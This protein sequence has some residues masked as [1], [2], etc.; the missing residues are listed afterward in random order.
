MTL[1]KPTDEDKR[2]LQLEATQL[3]NQR[4]LLGTIAVTAFGVIN[5]WII[6]K[7]T[8]Q[9]GDEVGRFRYL[10]SIILLIVLFS[11]FY[12]MHNLREMLRTISTYL[13]VTES[14]GWEIDWKNFKKKV[15][16]SYTRAQTTLFLVLGVLSASVPFILGIAYNLKFDPFDGAYAL[17]IIGIVYIIFLCGMGFGNWFNNECQVEKR[18]KELDNNPDN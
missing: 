13:V 5:T 9:L 7:E 12:L 4:F 17:I 1:H 18:W 16:P 2:K 8:P 3:V 11:L 10:T 6:P 15:Y 14:S